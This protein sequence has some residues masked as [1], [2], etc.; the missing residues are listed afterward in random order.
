MDFRKLGRL[1]KHLK[2]ALGK[3]YETYQKELPTLIP[4]TK[5]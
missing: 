2:K 5:K 1:R 3:Q 4:F